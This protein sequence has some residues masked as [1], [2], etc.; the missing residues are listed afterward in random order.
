M[1]GAIQR[2]QEF[3]SNKITH[4]CTLLHTHIQHTQHTYTH[5]HTYIRTYIQEDEKEQ[6]RRLAA[7]EKER[8]DLEKEEVKRKRGSEREAKERLRQEEILSKENKK[9]ILKCT[10]DKRKSESIDRNKVRAVY[11]K[12]FSSELKRVRSDAVV[13]VLQCFDAEETVQEQVEHT[14]YFLNSSNDP[15]FDTDTEE[16]DRKMKLAALFST[17][18][19]C[20]KEFLRPPDSSSQVK[21]GISSIHGPGSFAE[22]HNTS[23]DTAAT[24][25]YAY[26]GTAEPV[27]W[28]DVFQASTCLGVF[29]ERLQLQVPLTLEGLVKRIAHISLAGEASSSSFSSSSSTSSASSSSTSSSSTSTSSSSFSSSSRNHDPSSSSSLVL[30]AHVPG[31]SFTSE[32]APVG[33]STAHER[34]GSSHTHSYLD[35]NISTDTIVK[36]K[37]L[38]D[39][40]HASSSIKIEIKHD[41]AVT[42]EFKE[43]EKEVV[44]KIDTEVKE[45]GV[46]DGRS[47]VEYVKEEK[48]KCDMMM[49]VEDHRSNAVIPDRV[50]REEGDRESSSSVDQVTPSL[51]SA[52]VTTVVLEAAD[53]LEE[54]KADVLE[55]IKAEETQESGGIKEEV[56]EE[57]SSDLTAPPVQVINVTF[58]FIFCDDL[59]AAP[60]SHLSLLSLLSLFSLLSHPLSPFSLFSCLPYLTLIHTSLHCTTLLH[61]IVHY[62]MSNARC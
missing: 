11:R 49:D 33:S 53:V 28:D 34:N 20:D 29:S 2:M 45:V 12:D 1:C 24:S 30:N 26:I 47:G 41:V 42:Q 7:V 43:I 57:N 17:L 61:C 58:R 16:S 6:N 40:D 23:S 22:T 55:G 21:N 39:A 36:H 56:K 9:L 38:V 14:R 19:S 25:S 37:V 44:G 35:S 60:L 10:K 18:P 15:D 51:P 59:Y 5:T 8:K 4:Y 46:I 54:I 27:I 31:E 13:T 50:G 62:Y 48:I 52:V 32:N 3:L